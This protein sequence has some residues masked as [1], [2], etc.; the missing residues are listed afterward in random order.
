MTYINTAA[1]SANTEKFL[2]ACW[3]GGEIVIQLV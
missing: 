2:K 1:V 3:F